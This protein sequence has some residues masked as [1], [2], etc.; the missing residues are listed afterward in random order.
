MIAFNPLFCVKSRSI[1][2]FNQHHGFLLIE[3]EKGN[4]ARI[5]QLARAADL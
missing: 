1:F 2:Q 4:H 5:A 3:W